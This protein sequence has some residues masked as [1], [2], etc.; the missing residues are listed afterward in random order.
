LTTAFDASL[1]A[2]ENC[3]YDQLLASL[4]YQSVGLYAHR[5]ILEHERGVHYPF[6]PP[7]PTTQDSSDLAPSTGNTHPFQEQDPPKSPCAASN[8]E[9]SIDDT[10]HIQDQEPS[11]QIQK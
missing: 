2:M 8:L 9:P 4:Q 7:T 6:K 5:N 10:A 11:F 3:L 1:L